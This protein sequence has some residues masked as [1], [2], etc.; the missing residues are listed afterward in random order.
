MLPIVGKVLMKKIIF[1]PIWEIEDT[2]YPSPSSKNIPDW[3]KKTQPF[4][5]NDKHFKT[6]E[7]SPNLTVK[8]CIPV[9]DAITA[10]YIIKTYTDIY[11]SEGID[12]DKQYS[13]PTYEP[14]SFHPIEQAELHP[15]NNGLTYPKWTNP[16]SIETTSGYSCL[17]VPPMHNPNNY[18]TIM[19]GVV[20]T[21]RYI[22][23]VNFPFVL[24]DPNFEGIIPAGTP[25]A[26]VIPFKR[27]S[28]KHSIGNNHKKISSFAQIYRNR[29]VNN[30][31]NKFWQKKI[32]K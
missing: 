10:G 15:T 7:G 16:W 31:K 8:K 28:F 24:N 5:N 6:R 23:P 32:Y 19:P 11:V 1:T 2:F 25:M 3:Y 17:F 26:Q 27:D 20:D 21:D 14:I 4:L 9:F 29:F 22:N 12:G 18:F 30:Y 13:W